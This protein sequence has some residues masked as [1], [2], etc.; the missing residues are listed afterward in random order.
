MNYWKDSY[1][2]WNILHWED[3]PVWNPCSFYLIWS[4]KFLHDLDVIS[5]PSTLWQTLLFAV[6]FSI[7]Q[8][9]ATH[10]LAFVQSLSDVLQ[11][12]ANPQILEYSP[13]KNETCSHGATSPGGQRTPS[14]FIKNEQNAQQDVH[15]T[16]KMLNRMC[17]VDTLHDEELARLHQ[18]DELFKDL[19]NLSDS[20]YESESEGSDSSQ[21]ESWS[22]SSTSESIVVLCELLDAL[23]WDGT[24]EC[25]H[26]N[27]S[28]VFV[29]LGWI[30]D[31][32][33]M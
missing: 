6:Y 15:K 24:W 26:W 16:S 8:E 23:R 22:S 33:S 4:V 11:T 12:M 7:L 13:R 1:F 20:L 5:V 29:V 31:F 2:Q 30:W 28:Q 18:A 14:S 21:Y 9:T 17:N 19:N 27:S 3:D 25:V 32:D 10:Q